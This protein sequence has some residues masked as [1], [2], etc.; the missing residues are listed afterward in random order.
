MFWQV[1]FVA[2]ACDMQ[3]SEGPSRRIVAIIPD[4]PALEGEGEGKL[5]VRTSR[6]MFWP[7]GVGAYAQD[8][9]VSEAPSS[10]HRGHESRSRF[11]AGARWDK[12]ILS[13]E[14][15]ERYKHKLSHLQLRTALN[16]HTTLQQI[17]ISHS[18]HHI[19][20]ISL[21]HALPSTQRSRMPI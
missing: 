1:K 12:S 5:Y 10:S 14:Q 7:V 6:H 3:V 11:T 17:P 20:V 16:I 15:R 2:C 18:I 13:I 4:F 9:Q 8:M 21:R 19:P